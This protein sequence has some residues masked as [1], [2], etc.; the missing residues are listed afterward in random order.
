[1]VLALCASTAALAQQAASTP[2][3]K[4]AAQAPEKKICHTDAD[5]GSMIRTRTCHTK[6]EWDQIEASA[7]NSAVVWQG[8]QTYTEGSR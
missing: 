3:A 2:E 6:A 7:R 8:R 4:A 1:M 5:T